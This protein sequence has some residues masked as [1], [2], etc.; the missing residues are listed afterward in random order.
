MPLN[1]DKLFPESVIV[2]Q[3]LISSVAVSLPTK[4]VTSLGLV[5]KS[6]MREFAAGRGL[7]RRALAKFGVHDAPLGL[8]SNGQPIWPDGFTGSISHKGQYCV[9]AVARKACFLGLGIDIEWNE[10][11]E[12]VDL[13]S[14]CTPDERKQAALFPMDTCAFANL[15]FSA[16]EAFFKCQHAVTGVA[17]VGFLDVQP[18]FDPKVAQFTIEINDP[19]LRDILPQ[20]CWFDGRFLVNRQI[21]ASGVVLTLKG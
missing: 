16:K 13:D 2:E 8:G 4:E 10:P 21:V 12:E 7:A 17:D 1:L 15:L 6:R 18:L 11:F 3:G 9:V 14:I 5:S 20:N 19:R